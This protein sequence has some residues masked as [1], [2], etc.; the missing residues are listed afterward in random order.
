MSL[1]KFVVRVDNDVAWRQLIKEGSPET[2]FIVDAYASQWG[3]A[4]ALHNKILSVIMEGDNLD[5]VYVEALVDGIVQLSDQRHRS[6]PLVLFY[7]RGREVARVSGALPLDVERTIRR[8]ASAKLDVDASVVRATG[9]DLRDISD[10]TSGPSR[11]A[12]GRRPGDN[13]TGRRSRGLEP[14]DARSK[15]RQYNIVRHA[16]RAMVYRPGPHRVLH[17]PVLRIS[18]ARAPLPPHLVPISY[19]SRH[20]YVMPS[21]QPLTNRS[22]LPHHLN[23]QATSR[24]RS[25]ARMAA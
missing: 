1:L 14:P 20:A 2:L 5:I 21:P 13:L 6:K 22:Q 12:G 16:D 15:E 10:P 11:R 17:S 9:V 3:V 18:C 25:A 7:K 24:V 8:F 23:S 19:P 4:E